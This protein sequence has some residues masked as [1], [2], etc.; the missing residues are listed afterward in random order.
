M[1]DGTVP[2]NTLLLKEIIKK[3]NTKHEDIR[4][5]AG[6][7]STINLRRALAGKPITKQ[8][9]QELAEALQVVPVRL[10][11]A[12]SGATYEDVLRGRGETSTLLTAKEGSAPETHQ[13][14]RTT[15]QK[16]HGPEM[17]R[18]NAV[19]QIV[20]D[21][22]ALDV[23]SSPDRLAGSANQT[24]EQQRNAVLKWHVEICDHYVAVG[25]MLAANEHLI[26][27]D[28]KDRVMS[29]FLVCHEHRERLLAAA[30]SDSD[31]SGRESTDLFF[32]DIKLKSQALY[33]AYE[34]FKSQLAR[35]VGR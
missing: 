13:A 22:L 11:L 33:A 2:V 35:L 9:F 26:D 20:E 24:A 29:A 17:L 12:D 28:L 25:N 5:K 31:L 4:K 14:K 18:Y 8:I 27:A 7:S 10:L 16:I 15:V 1:R 19:K 30:N 21:L 3:D 23:W 6:W 32:T 34:G